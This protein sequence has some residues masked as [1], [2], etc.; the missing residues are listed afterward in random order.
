[1]QYSST[2][3]REVPLT[4]NAGRVV[5]AV[6]IAYLYDVY[7]PGASESSLVPLSVKRSTEA[8]NDSM[9]YELQQW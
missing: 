3:F 1:M 2:R 7:Q 5:V 4:S 9:H 8:R 6:Q